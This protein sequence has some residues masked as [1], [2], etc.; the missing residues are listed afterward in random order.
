MFFWE[1]ERGVARDGWGDGEKL[2]RVEGEETIVRIYYIRKNLFPIKGKEE[3][4]SK[5]L[6]YLFI[7]HLNMADLILD[8][9]VL[10]YKE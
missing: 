5:G 9:P 6:T 4:S 8:F 1:T 7:R 3:R 2:G 10:I